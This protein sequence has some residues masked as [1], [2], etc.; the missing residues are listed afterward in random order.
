MI[1]YF[2]PVSNLLRT[3][4][5]YIVSLCSER[6]FC[7]SIC[8]HGLW[9]YHWAPLKRGWVQLLM[10]SL[11]VF[12][13]IA[14]IPL[15]FLSSTLEI[16]RSLS[17]CPYDRCFNPW[18]IFLAL[19][20]PVSSVAL[21]ALYWEAQHWTPYSRQ[22]QSWVIFCVGIHVMWTEAAVVFSCR[23][24][25]HVGST[26]ILARRHLHF[27]FWSPNSLHM[28][29]QKCDFRRDPTITFLHYWHILVAQQTH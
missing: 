20:Q 23:E 21:S 25:I 2:S 28:N 26:F 10:P 24:Y 19:C 1:L 12:M 7:V 4:C 3:V 15:S 14:E 27:W 11:Q 6:P 16:P 22:F 8:S 13:Y 9:S 5:S 18:V 17:L 29:F